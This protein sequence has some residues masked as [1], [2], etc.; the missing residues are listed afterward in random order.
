MALRRYDSNRGI[1]L[2][3]FANRWIFGRIYRSLMGT[4]NLLHNRKIQTMDLNDKVIDYQNLIDAHRIDLFEQID[5]MTDKLASSVLRMVF[6]NYKRSEILK[7][8]KISL[9][10]YNQ[11]LTD[12]K[13]AFD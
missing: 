6:M 4:Q 1:S 8:N 5:S 11:I 13:G 10:Q 2:G 9:D 7:V 12:F 3:A